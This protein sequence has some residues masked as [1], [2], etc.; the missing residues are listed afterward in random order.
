MHTIAQTIGAL[1]DRLGFPADATAALQGQARQLS[2]HPAFMAELAGWQEK[3][4]EMPWPA[5][6]RR[7]AVLASWAQ[8]LSLPAETL[9]LLA[10]LSACPGLQAAY[11][12]QGIPEELYWAGLSDFRSKLL[13][14][15]E[16]RGVNGTF[17]PGW[18]EGMF[19][20]RRFAL[21]RFQYAT[22][23]LEKDYPLA[24]GRV[25]PAGSFKAACHIPS[26]GPGLSDD[27]RLDSYRKAHAF[28]LPRLHQG[29]LL[30]SCS[31][32]LLYPA[33]A[34][35][36]P[37]ASHI[38]RFMGD[39]T[40]ISHTEQPGF[41]DGW[42]VFGKA[43]GTPYEDLPEDTALRR[44]YKQWLLKAGVTGRGFG[45]LVF[46]GEKIIPACKA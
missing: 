41:P 22:E 10:L 4:L 11:A 21:G 8:E 24:D 13:E 5:A 44:A 46:D 36:L 23:T 25:V 34:Q 33:Q 16:L 31:S 14:C 26:H 15:R 37:G 28:F 2:A 3:M 43:W 7:D 40:L 27:V 18:F 19:R 45:I 6:E 35:F 20:L 32:W 30:V 17:V 42:R 9:A 12:R 38:L 1:G 29:L 39:F